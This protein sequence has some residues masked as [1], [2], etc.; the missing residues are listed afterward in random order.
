[1]KSKL[2]LLI[3]TLAVVSASAV[4]CISD[5]KY[6]CQNVTVVADG[7]PEGDVFTQHGCPDQVIELGNEVGQNIKKWNKYLVV[8]RR[9]EGHKLLGTIFQEDA[10]SNVAYLIEG[11]KVVK[12]GYVGEGKGSAILMA[13]KDA[14]HNR[15]RAGYGGDYGWSGSYGQ[16]GRRGNGMWGENARETVSNS[17]RAR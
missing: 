8:Y 14:M 13:L 4:G 3:G 2:S 12:G 1:M 6:G 11:G 15:V 17:S 5:H 10:F 9:G 16:S 7:S